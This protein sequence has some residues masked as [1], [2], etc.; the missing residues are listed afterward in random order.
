[1]SQDINLVK[2]NLEFLQQAKQEIF[3][4]FE[5][6]RNNFDGSD[7]QQGKK[8]GLRLALAL[9]GNPKWASFNRGQ[10]LSNQSEKEETK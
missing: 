1:M 5:D 8:D 3:E 9:L 10:A 7:Y 4:L 6:V 2:A